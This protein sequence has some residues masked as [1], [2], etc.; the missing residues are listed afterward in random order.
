MSAGQGPAGGGDAERLAAAIEQGTT[1]RSAGDAE[2]A[3]DLEIV[4]M[5]RSRSAA[6]D[7]HPGDRARAKQRLMAALAQSGDGSG[8][9][10]A[11]AAELTAPLGRITDDAPTEAIAVTRE[12]VVGGPPAHPET[13]TDPGTVV[14]DA[15][16][17]EAP[18]VAGT[19]PRRAG[20][21]SLPSRP[22]GR[23]RGASR[24]GRGGLRR[25]MV[26]VGAAVL[27]AVLAFTGA[28]LFSRDALPGDTFY[29]MKR[30]SEST[31]TALTFDDQDR[32]QRHL[33]LATTRMNE[34][35]QLVARGSASGAT[36]PDAALVESAMREFDGSTGEGSRMLLTAGDPSGTAALGDLWAWAADQSARLSVLR[37]ALPADSVDE[38][39][40]SL[41]LLD[42]LLV[43]T[44]ALQARSSC[45]E[46]TSSVVDDLGPLPAEGDCSP[47]VSAPSP[48]STTNT[49]VGS[50]SDA[51]T[52]AP[53]DTDTTDPTT[54]T[55]TDTGPVT[56][57]PTTATSPDGDGGLLP[58]LGTDGLPLLDGEGSRDGLSTSTAPEDDDNVSIPLPLLPP[59][60]LPPLLPGL[61]GV[62]IG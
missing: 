15:P 34:V 49:E 19:R 11:R 2:L 26:M 38:A 13:S 3:R 39:D 44:E 21:H 6:F 16:A 43:R 36:A 14:A 18:D 5:L 29:A 57:T 4:A 56:G 45:S 42:R 62:S 10:Q 59:V 20:R 24:P 25:R 46:V 55:D 9:P 28:D 50:E 52:T 58:R 53:E 8:P 51:T 61:P 40:D 33:A 22:D 7:P 1:P 32:A 17:A 31:G 30:L 12:P 41:A 47:R 60:Q 27:A 37:S 48:D 35:E 23:A 54:G